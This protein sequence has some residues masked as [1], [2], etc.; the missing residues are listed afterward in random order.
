MAG[1]ESAATLFL[2]SGMTT[3]D[4]YST[5]NSSPWTAESF[6]ADEARAA[7]L[8]EYVRHAIVFSMAY[9]I[10]AAV[11]VIGDDDEDNNLAWYPIIGA[12]VANLYLAWLYRRASARGKT[13]G[14]TGWANG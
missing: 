12:G 1:K 10:A 5:L 4:A 3:F 11:I 8:R 7:L 14:N 9:A 6:G 2:I 13:A